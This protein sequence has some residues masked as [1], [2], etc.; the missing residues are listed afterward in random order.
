MLNKILM[1]SIEKLE[2]VEI[3]TSTPIHIMFSIKV[4]LVAG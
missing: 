1:F 3:T 2:V 4:K